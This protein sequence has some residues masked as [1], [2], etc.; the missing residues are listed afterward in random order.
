MEQRLQALEA[1]LV[2]AVG[3]RRLKPDP[4]KF[5]QFKEVRSFLKA[6]RRY[7]NSFSATEQ[8]KKEA[9]YLA[10]QTGQD[11]VRI[12]SV[13]TEVDNVQV[14]YDALETILITKF[15]PPSESNLAKEEFKAR[16][17]SAYE[18]V[19]AYVS[20]KRS[21]YEIAYPQDGRDTNHFLKE[22]CC[23]L[24]HSGLRKAILTNFASL[25]FTNYETKVQDALIG[26]KL[27]LEQ[28]LTDSNSPLGLY[29]SQGKTPM[30]AKLL[31]P[32]EDMEIDTLQP[33]K[34]CYKCGRPG[35]LR[36]DCRQ[37]AGGGKSKAG[38]SKK[39]GTDAK[40]GPCFRCLADGHFRSTCRVKPEKL[41]MA[42]K[43]NQKAR[44]DSGGNNKPNPRKTQIH[45]VE[46]DDT[47]D[48]DEVIKMLAS[49][50]INCLNQVKKDF[51]SGVRA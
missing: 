5:T 30:E 18:P 22:L 38:P 6:Y 49:A 15:C 27:I 16:R 33:T 25:D 11:R 40:K 37:N 29:T 17:Q 21:L 42:R 48:E 50:E 34:L 4:P 31:P 20:D 46:V 43:R 7:L 14:G 8:E 26:Q 44:S 36:R 28:Q 9:L 23:G 13:E 51:Q 19:Q 2:H 41:E 45:Q 3:G 24:Y 39:P 35:H 47:N 1:A 10:L 12:T 32:V